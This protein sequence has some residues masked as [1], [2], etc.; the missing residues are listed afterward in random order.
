MKPFFNL[1]CSEFNF[2]KAL[3]VTGT[4]MYTKLDKCVAR[5]TV[6][7]GVCRVDNDIYIRYLMPLFPKAFATYAAGLGMC[8]A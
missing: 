5:S 8:G 4:Y 1:Y 2:F 6:L 7:F 3:Y